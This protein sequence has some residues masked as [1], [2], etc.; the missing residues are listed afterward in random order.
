MAELSEEQKRIRERIE[1]L[2]SSGDSWNVRCAEC[3]N[4]PKEFSRGLLWDSDPYQWSGGDAPRDW[5]SQP[6]ERFYVRIHERLSCGHSMIR[7]TIPPRLQIVRVENNSDIGG[8]HSLRTGGDKISGEFRNN[9]G[10]RFVS[11][12]IAIDL[13]SGTGAMIGTTTTELRNVRSFTTE[14][15]SAEIGKTK[16]AAFM[17]SGVT[18]LSPGA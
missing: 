18:D 3:P 2:R 17:I 15:W 16:A 10:E 9:C 8:R 6:Y 5:N 7:I 13:F 4:E 1:K 11:V 14:T 12:R